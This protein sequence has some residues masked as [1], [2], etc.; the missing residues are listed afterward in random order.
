MT[1]PRIPFPAWIFALA[2]LLGGLSMAWIQGEAARAA[3]PL[4]GSGDLIQGI[5]QYRG[6]NGLYAYGRDSTLMDIANEQS[7]YMASTGSITHTGSGGTRPID[8][9][10]AAG[11][12]GGN[13]IWVSEIIYGGYQASENDAISWW[14]TSQIH[15]DTMLSS[16]YVHIGAGVARSGQNNYYTV[17]VGVISGERAEVDDTAPPAAAAEPEII[18]PVE[19]SEP[20]ADGS[21]VH[22]VREGQSPW[23]I[24]YAYEVPLGNLLALNGLNLDSLLYE[25]QELL[26]RSEQ[27]TAPTATLIPT[28]RVLRSPTAQSQ[29]PSF[30]LPTSPP[31]SPSPTSEHTDEAG[32]AEAGMSPSLFSLG[33]QGLGAAIL[34]A[35]ILGF[36]LEGRGPSRETEN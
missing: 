16:Q 32:D 19:R 2:L 35:G 25:G 11:Y 8:R 1:N 21:I 4:P 17:V 23:L 15:N 22:T 33:V 12:G 30:P 26:I 28:A 14:K 24:A 7:N 31:P 6:N 34:V 36:L 20:R 18:V 10:Y 9:A 29:A 5:N 13:T 27:E 3:A